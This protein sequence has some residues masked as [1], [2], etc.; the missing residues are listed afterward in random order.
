MRLGNQIYTYRTANGLSQGALAEK[1][2]VSRQAVSKWEND[3]AVPELEKLQAASQLFGV[4][5]DELVTGEAGPSAAAPRPAAS[6]LTVPLPVN[7]LAGLLLLGVSLWGILLQAAEQADAYFL[8][9]CLLGGVLCLL[10]RRRT[11]LWCVWAAYLTVDAAITEH[12]WDNWWSL[13]HIRHGIYGV[14]RFELDP[15]VQVLGIIAIFAGTA[16][17]FRRRPLCL[18]ARRRCVFRISA[19]AGTAVL[20]FGLWWLL[21]GGLEEKLLKGAVGLVERYGDTARFWICLAGF[22]EFTF[23]E[24]VGQLLLCALAAALVLTF[25]KTELPSVR[26]SL[27]T[28]I[29]ALR[30]GQGLSQGDLAEQ[31]DVSRQSVSKWETGRAVPELE[32]LLALSRRFGVSLEMLLRREGDPASSV[33]MLS[34]AR[35]LGLG[36]LLLGAHEL[37]QWVLAYSRDAEILAPLLL[38]LCGAACLRWPHRL[39]L[40][41]GWAAGLLLDATMRMNSSVYALQLALVPGLLFLTLYTFRQTVF[42]PTR[43][44]WRFLLGG[45]CL[46]AVLEGALL[47]RE[48][49][50]AYPLALFP[51]G[52]QILFCSAADGV[53]LLVFSALLTVTV[54]FLRGRRQGS[55]SP[56]AEPDHSDGTPEPL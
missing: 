18:G 29:A 45:W 31:L 27:G 2:G 39:V 25:A 42:R 44:G 33:T 26:D 49:R 11:A 48:Y 10:E 3:S 32:K 23:S 47:W 56:S 54:G 20:A 35:L 5:L 14:Q 50:A 21:F 34:P 19:W 41:C 12:D 8:W 51:A 55:G 36:L 13:F 24:R 4:S 9:P 28:R 40:S 6:G 16:W 37:F 17:H 43:K 38:L 53:S 46:W 7:R 30:T 22:S 52:P 1:L 15:W